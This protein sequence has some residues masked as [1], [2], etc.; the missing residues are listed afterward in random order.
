MHTY[1][2]IHMH[3]SVT[4]LNTMQDTTKCQ[5]TQNSLTLQDTTTCCN[6]LQHTATRCNPIIEE[7]VNRITHG[8]SHN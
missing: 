5:M 3:V 8:G 2:C 1:I 7:L 4:R 6:T